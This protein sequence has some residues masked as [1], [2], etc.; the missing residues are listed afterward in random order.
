MKLTY[1][2]KDVILEEAKT[3]LIVEISQK[4]KDEILAK[5]KAE[6][7]DKIPAIIKN[8]ESFEKYQQGLPIDKRNLEKYTYAQLKKLIESKTFKTTFKNTFSLFKQKNT[9]VNDRL[10][11]INIKKF[12]EIKSGLSENKQDI[13]EYSYITLDRLIEQNYLNL[14]IKIYKPIFQKESPQVNEATIIGHLRTYDEV[15]DE[16]PIDTKPIN[17]MT[18]DE[19]EHMLASV[20]TNKNIIKKEV[21][22][23]SD[24][25]LVYNEDNQTI[26]IPKN[27]EECIRYKRGRSW[28]IT[29][30]GGSNR[31]YN[32][33]LESGLTIYYTID[34]DIPYDDV[35]HIMV[36][37][38][39]PNGS[40][41]CA[42][43][44]NSGKWSG[45]QVVSW[46][47]IVE[48]Q[49]KLDNLEHLFVPIPLTPEEEKL[50][51]EIRNKNVGDNPFDSFPNEEMVGVWIELLPQGKTLTDKQYSNLTSELKRKYI[52][53]DYKLTAG[54]INNTEENIINYYI[55][56]SGKRLL[57]KTLNSIDDEDIALLNLPQNWAIKEEL[58]T[59]FLTQLQP[60][61]TDKVVI[62]YPDSGISKYV[63]L[64]GTTEI[65]DN[66]QDTTIWFKFF[67][68]SKTHIALDLTNISK[69][70]D[71][72]ALTIDNAVDTIPNNILQLTNL[73]TL[74]IINCPNITSLPPVETMESLS[75]VNISGSINIKPSQE[76]LEKFH[77]ASDN[78]GFYFVEDL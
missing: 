47:E 36:I 35:N 46:S 52:S 28:C 8:I 31:Y 62:K 69:L 29:W 5:F 22:D 3:K 25:N 32:Y 56:K 33:R 40:K 67:N 14:L 74:T 7:T 21:E 2:L 73:H 37:L 42:D 72:E 58:K 71:L 24:V 43:K 17:F 19:F 41:R 70:K 57:D 68:K 63:A 53:A 78:K 4:K 49:P 27:K 39:E 34:E 18:Y 54:Q 51:K 65:I 59:K 1:F 66:L 30:P 38:V 60:S 48:K 6:T 13:K 9:N 12:L 45:H 55:K 77:E 61:N 15:Y 11:S 10:L 50:V 76:F 44:T 75:F 23:F 16:L 26:F 64:Y 20:Q